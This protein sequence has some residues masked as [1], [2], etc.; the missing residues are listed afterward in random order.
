MP[1]AV[2]GSTLAAIERW[3]I[4]TGQNQCDGAIAR[5]QRDLPSNSRLITNVILTAVGYNLRLILT[6]LSSLLRFILLGLCRALT[7]TPALKWTVR[8]VSLKREE[9]LDGAAR[10]AGYVC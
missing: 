9:Q 2:C 8:G 7:V 4:L 3:H 10:R 1:Q 6:W 5:L